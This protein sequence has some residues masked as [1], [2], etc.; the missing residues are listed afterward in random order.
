MCL[1]ENQL[2]RYRR[3]AQRFLNHLLLCIFPPG[4]LK[5]FETAIELR[6]KYSLSYFVKFEGF[7]SSL[8]CDGF[9]F[10]DEE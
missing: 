5:F 3:H 4:V 7:F 9:S 1:L 10:L 8:Q 6:S 2:N